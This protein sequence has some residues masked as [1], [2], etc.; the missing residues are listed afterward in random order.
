M[1]IVQQTDVHEIVE[2]VRETVPDPGKGGLHAAAPYPRRE[3]S[4]R[5]RI[6]SDVA[7]DVEVKRLVTYPCEPISDDG[8]RDALF[9]FDLHFDRS[10]ERVRRRAFVHERRWTYLEEEIHLGVLRRLRLDLR[11]RRRR[12]LRFGS[13]L[14]RGAS[15]VA[16]SF[17][18]A[19][20]RSDLS[21]G[22]HDDL[23]SARL[24]GLPPS[25]KAAM[26]FRGERA[27][28]QLLPYVLEHF[29]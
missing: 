4:R 5:G 18:A 28:A 21:Q 25:E 8:L 24:P 15:R 17:E 20:V 7:R 22:W 13:M 1:R 10:L 19:G 27:M 6:D 29:E 11:R 9:G 2:S 26:V 3:R 16:L 14:T 12:R 23:Y